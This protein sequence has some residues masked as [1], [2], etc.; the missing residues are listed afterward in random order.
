MPRKDGNC[1]N[2]CSGGKDANQALST[3]SLEVLSDSTPFRP[4]VY[5]S[6]FHWLSTVGSAVK[7]GAVRPDSGA[8]LPNMSVQVPAV[9]VQSRPALDT[10]VS[11]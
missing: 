11:S 7:S 1:Q 4:T 2:L 6:A 8:M 9:V 3:G 5:T 10:A